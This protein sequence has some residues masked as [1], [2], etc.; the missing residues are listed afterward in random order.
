MGLWEKFSLN[1]KEPDLPRR[2]VER[3]F[4]LSRSAMRTH[5]KTL[6]NFSFKIVWTWFNL[7]ALVTHK[8]KEEL[9]LTLL[10]WMSRLV[11]D[12]ISLSVPLCSSNFECAFFRELDF[13]SFQLSCVSRLCIK[14]MFGVRKSNRLSER[15]RL[16]RKK[17]DYSHLL[18]SDHIIWYHKGHI[19]N[20]SVPIRTF[21]RNERV[22][23]ENDRTRVSW[24]QVCEKLIKF[25]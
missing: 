24:K 19:N 16:S 8:S 10:R 2:A 15:V 23:E 13:K 22:K 1:S 9:V 4:G 20:L 18:T 17:D 11:H 21:M 3:L 12:A 14:I 25:D 7:H 6:D 5:L